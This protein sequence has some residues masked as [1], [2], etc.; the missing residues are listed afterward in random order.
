MHTKPRLFPK[1]SLRCRSKAFLILKSGLHGNKKLQL[2]GRNPEELQSPLE[3]F[4]RAE[5]PVTQY[6]VDWPF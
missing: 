5:H 4:F 2:D 1:P 3:E 6:K